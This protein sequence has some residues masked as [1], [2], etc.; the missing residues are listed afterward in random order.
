MGVG[1]VPVGHHLQVSCHNR[2][3]I[4]IV[5]QP[6]LGKT[7]ITAL[8]RPFAEACYAGTYRQECR[9]FYLDTLGGQLQRPADTDIDHSFGPFRT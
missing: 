6:G 1:S 3:H 9:I 5:D 8:Q 4:V 2:K 7:S